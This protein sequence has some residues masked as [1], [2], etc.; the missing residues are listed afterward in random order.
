MQEDSLNKEAITDDEQH[1]FDTLDSQ[2]YFFDA[3]EEEVKSSEPMLNS[4]ILALTTSK[5]KDFGNN[6]VATFS[7]D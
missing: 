1:F 6:S 4:P 2:D 5:D 7:S 3:V